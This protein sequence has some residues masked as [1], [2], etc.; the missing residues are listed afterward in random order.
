MHRTKTQ[1]SIS[2]HWRSGGISRSTTVVCEDYAPR[3]LIPWLLAG[4]QLPA[5]GVAGQRLDYV[6]RHGIAGDRLLSPELILSKQHVSNGSHLW[7]GLAPAHAATPLLRRCLLGFPGGSALLVPNVG[8]I[9]S[10]GWLLQAL[11]LLDPAVQHSELTLLAQGHSAY[12]YVSRQPHCE[13]VLNEQSEWSA[14]SGRT[15]VVSRLNGVELQPHIPVVLGAGDRLQLGVAG[16]MLTIGM[17]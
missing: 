3:D 8:L 10:R 1:L 9:I 4:C 13:I 6:L 17:I 15:D 11:G 16:P 12:R 7:L 14:Y 5:T 2:L